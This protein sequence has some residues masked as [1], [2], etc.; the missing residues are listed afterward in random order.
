MFLARIAEIILGNYSP[1]LNRRM[2]ENKRSFSCQSNL[3][4]CVEDEKRNFP[5]NLPWPA[6][7]IPRNE[8]SS[9]CLVIE[10]FALMKQKRVELAKSVGMCWVTVSSQVTGTQVSHGLPKAPCL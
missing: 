1:C 2:F 10:K 6:T 7:G 3:L 9:H 8:F 5:E 4:F